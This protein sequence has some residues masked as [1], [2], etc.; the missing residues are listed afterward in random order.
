MDNTRIYKNAFSIDFASIELE[1]VITEITKFLQIFKKL[2]HRTIN[3]KICKFTAYLLCY[4]VDFLSV[5]RKKIYLYN[6]PTVRQ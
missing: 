3:Q 6:Q 5:G 1:K 2:Y 4:Y